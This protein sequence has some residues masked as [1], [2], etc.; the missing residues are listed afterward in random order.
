MKRQLPAVSLRVGSSRWLAGFLLLTH[1][2]ALSLVLWLGAAD[3]R[4]LWWLPALGLSLLDAWRRQL[5][6]GRELILEGSGAWRLRD[7]DGS[8]QDAELLDDSRV[9]PGLMILGLRLENGR[10][11][12]LILLPDNSDA[13][14]RRRLRVR[15]TTDRQS[16]PGPA[17]RSPPSGTEAGSKLSG[18]RTVGRRWKRSSRRGKSRV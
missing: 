8:V 5:R 7:R 1:L 17:V 9:W 10:R 6:G 15:L 12:V 18:I 2:P 13:E 4:F 16:L 14:Q 11:C 3:P